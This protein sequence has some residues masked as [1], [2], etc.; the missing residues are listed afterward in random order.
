MG[1]QNVMERNNALRKKYPVHILDLEKELWAR[2]PPRISATHSK[3]HSALMASYDDHC[4]LIPVRQRF[5]GAL[6][7]SLATKST[8]ADALLKDDNRAMDRSSRLDWNQ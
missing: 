6:I 7:I 5:Q 8:V 4:N 2:K 3:V 1:S